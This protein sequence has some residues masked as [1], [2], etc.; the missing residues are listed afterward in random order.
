VRIAED[1]SEMLEDADAIATGGD[2]SAF[3]LGAAT[4]RASRTLEVTRIEGESRQRFYELMIDPPA[5]SP[6]L[7]KVLAANTFEDLL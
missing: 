5:P 4:A 2:V 3:V 7:K 1:V 6:A